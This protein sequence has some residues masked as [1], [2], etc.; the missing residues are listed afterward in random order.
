MPGAVERASTSRST[1]LHNSSNLK[2]LASENEWVSPF[3]TGGNRKSL[4]E[5]LTQ[6]N[7]ISNIKVPSKFTSHEILQEAEKEKSQKNEEATK[8]E[9]SAEENLEERSKDEEGDVAKEAV[10]ESES[11]EKDTTIGGNETEKAEP[12]NKEKEDLALKGDTESE[13]PLSEEER[14]HL[15]KEEAGE[16]AEGKKGDNEGEEEPIDIVEQ[17]PTPKVELVKLPNQEIMEK[18]KDK[19]KMLQHF[20]QLNASAYESAF[21]NLNDPN[22]VIDVGA[23]LKMTRQLLL[24]MAAKR[25]APV[26]SN[27]EVEISK[28]RKEDDIKREKQYGAK[29]SSHEKK[30]LNSFEKYK[31]KILKQ[32]GKYDADHTEKLNDLEKKKQSADS[33]AVAFEGE[34]KED[35]EKANNDYETR[36][37][38][39]GNKH[40]LDKET[41]LRNH[42]ELVTIKKKELEE[43]I[44]NLE[45]TSK[46]INE[47]E[48]AREALEKNNTELSSKINK[49]KSQ[50]DEVAPELEDLKRKTFNEKEV[51]DRYNSTRAELNGKINESQEK[52]NHKK[53]RHSTLLEEIKDL[54]EK[55]SAYG[56]KSAYL[57]SV[58]DEHPKRLADARNKSRA[59]ENERQGIANDVA[60]ED[61]RKRLTAI[62]QNKREKE[63]AKAVHE[64]PE[65]SE[66]ESPKGKEAETE[67]SRL[68]NGVSDSSPKYSVKRKPSTSKSVEKPKTEIGKGEES[69]PQTKKPN[70]ERPVSVTKK[71][72]TEKPP[73]QAKGPEVQ[74]PALQPKK[75]EA[76]KPAPQPKKA[77]AEKPAPQPKKAEAEKPAP[78][79]RKSEE[80]SPAQTKK[81]G[82]GEKTRRR[83]IFSSPFK[84]R[85]KSQEKP[86]VGSTKDKDSEYDDISLYEEVSEEEFNKYKN[87]P[88]YVELTSDEI[89]RRNRK[90]KNTHILPF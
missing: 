31:K 23:G 45:N 19:P 65:I 80:K 39:A 69:A 33:D 73:P 41:L 11:G 85:G 44:A 49:T 37:E 22:R 71:V 28:S 48:E 52:L 18:L 89:K 1:S 57:Q 15:D 87:N 36:K 51:V 56:T 60:R 53:E 16:K 17:P 74:K 43:T 20:Q 86:S 7:S 6:Q 13:R 50:L 47:L 63:L 68:N 32:K 54:K 25:V 82:G 9:Q 24:D 40:L 35:I 5:Q 10:E 34:I 77:E 58:I 84:K 67:G 75:V 38:E 83:S 14:K 90:H 72:E 66:F 81:S 21:N 42:E 70:A 12:E 4:R 59:W 55:L 79:P 62:A 76:E 78:Q 2:K 30:L 8:G 26:L 64:A 29:V 46:E 3:R 88:D 27:I 61:E